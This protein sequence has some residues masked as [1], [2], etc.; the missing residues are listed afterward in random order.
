MSKKTNDCGDIGFNVD[1]LDKEISRCVE[2]LKAYEE[3]GPMGAFAVS[4]LRPKITDGLK[5]IESGNL[6][7]MKRAYFGLVGCA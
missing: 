4:I 5:A 3:I 6:I 2:I 1:K 7:A